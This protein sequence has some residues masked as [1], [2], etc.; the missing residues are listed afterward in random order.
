MRIKFSY[1]LA[2]GL[3]A[4]VAGWMLTGATIVAGVSD[5]D[6][7][8]PPPA[9]RVPQGSEKPFAVRVKTIHAEERSAVLDIRGRTEAEA[10]VAIRAETSGRI[11]ERP[12]TE[13][14]TIAAG[15]TL[16]VLDKGVREAKVLEARAGLAQA[17]LDFKAATSLNTKGFTAETR[18]AALKAARDAAKARL[19]EAELELSYTVIAAPIGGIVESPVAEIG[20]ILDKGD[21]CA[22]IV[23]ADPILAIGQVSEQ[24]VGAISLGQNADVSLVTGEKA[25]G[26]VRYIAPSADPDTR[27]FRVEIEIPN[28][29]GLLRDGITALAQ[30][31]L[32]K[33]KAHRI[34]PAILTLNDQGRVGLRLV[35]DDDRVQFV[36]VTV[37]GGETDG[38]WVGGLPDTARIIT[39]GQDYVVEGQ[40]VVPVLDTAETAR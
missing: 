16:C 6:D 8:T 20:T 31:P 18:V 13:G 26:E 39:V 25:K 35:G 5:A 29:D 15:E 36:P 7:A 30:L 11:V 33:G 14:S 21:T 3:S 1:V 37:L 24:N 23:D 4:A 12:V 40:K 32:S 17:E 9:E 28:K 19:D 22:T 10:K 34:T 38:M 2:A 27:T